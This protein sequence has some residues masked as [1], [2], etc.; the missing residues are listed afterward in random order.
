MFNI[1]LLNNVGLQKIISR[2]KVG[3][4]SNKGSIIFEESM[5]DEEIN[6]DGYD[7]VDNSNS[8]LL[9]YVVAIISALLLTVF[10]FIDY[11]EIFEIELNDD[12]VISSLMRLFDESETKKMVNYI[13]I[14]ENIKLSLSIDDLDKIKLI[15]TVLKE[16]SYSYKVYEDYGYNYNVEIISKA[17][18]F[19]KNDN[20]TKKILASIV[21]KHK[22]RTNIKIEKILKSTTFISNHKTIFNILEQI[23]GLGTI[24]ISPESNS[25]FIILEFSY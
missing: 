6:N 21:E 16:D 18:A 7:N 14:S 24:K 5:P 2:Q 3:N 19:R 22:N 20:K 10:A 12:I 23:L 17:I 25:D 11:Q 13:S 4:D 8:S 1:D 15:K 9:S